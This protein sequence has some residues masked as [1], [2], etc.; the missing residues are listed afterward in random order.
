MPGH[1]F[2]FVQVLR[3][4]QQGRDLWALSVVRPALAPGPGLLFA[5]GG[6]VHPRLL[7][8]GSGVPTETPLQHPAGVSVVYGHPEP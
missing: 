2:G 4:N 3:P 6:H 7:P 8:A 1:Q 5:L